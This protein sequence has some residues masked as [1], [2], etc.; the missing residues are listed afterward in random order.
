[1]DTL[2]NNMDNNDY[3]LISSSI[4][5]GIVSN[6]YKLIFTFYTNENI[7]MIAD[8]YSYYGE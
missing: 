7:T 6:I 5:I 8:E 2:C 3:I 4:L 1:M